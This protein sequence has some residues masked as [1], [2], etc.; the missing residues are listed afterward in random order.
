MKNLSFELYIGF[1]SARG[2]ISKIPHACCDFALT[3]SLA[4]LQCL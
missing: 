2:L 3:A 1:D 4:E